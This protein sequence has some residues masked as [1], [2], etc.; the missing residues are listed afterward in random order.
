MSRA[1][2][3]S[4]GPERGRS[5]WLHRFAVLTAWCTFVLIFI[6]GLVTSTG[7][8]LAVP[9]WPLAF[10][11]VFP[12]MVGGV[13]Y[14]HGHRLAASL[15]GL[16]TVAL[17]VWILR[18]ESRRWVRG[19][20]LAGLG[21]VLL[22]GLLGGVTVLLELPTAVS[23]AHA[24]LAQ[25]FFCA[26]V[27]LALVTNPDW[28]AAPRRP[29]G[30][31]EAGRPSLHRL[32]AATA[33]VVFLQL[34]LGA[35]MRH[36]QAGL[37][38]PEFPLAFGRIIPPLNDPRV[39]IHFLHRMGAVAVTGFV[40]WTVMRVVRRRPGEPRLVE[41]KLAGPAVALAALLAF[42]LV[43][44]AL[45]IWTRMAGVPTTAPVTGGAA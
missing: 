38:I 32:C 8:S 42:Q 13:L 18:K 34:L 4:G 1:E 11:R 45:T 37:A 43:L 35:W 16:L 10:G 19:L 15:V 21:A 20:A 36:T 24:L 27:A 2:P 26:M 17:T 25:V 33:G 39:V 14:E 23:V 31:A 28:A 6:G 3:Q 44:G 12:P 41:P 40:V 7:S 9:D 29:A 30:P 5:P 22:Q